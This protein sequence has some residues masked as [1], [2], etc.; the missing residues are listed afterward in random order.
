MAKDYELKFKV[1]ELSQTD[2]SFLANSSSD[3]YIWS[4]D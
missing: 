2:F 4:Y 3:I 1:T